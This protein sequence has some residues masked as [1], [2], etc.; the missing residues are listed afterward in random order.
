MEEKLWKSLEDLSRMI[1]AKIGCFKNETSQL[2]AKFRNVKFSKFYGNYFCVLQASEIN[3]W[4]F[5][6]I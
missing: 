1:P 3:F 4:K 5:S 2:E 6:A